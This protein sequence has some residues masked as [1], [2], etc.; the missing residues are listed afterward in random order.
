MGTSG[1][2]KSTLL[3]IMAA[4][5]VPKKA[6]ITLISHSD[7]ELSLKLSGLSGSDV[8]RSHVGVV[9]QESHIFSESV[10]FN[11]SFEQELTGEFQSFW[12][13]VLKKISYLGQWGITPESTLDPKSISLGQRQLIAAI[14]ACYLKKSIILF[15]EISSGLDSDLEEAL[16]EVILL[17]QRESMTFV[18]AHRMETVL[19]ADSILLLEDGRLISSGNH[20][21][22]MENSDSYRNFVFELS[23]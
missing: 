3:N 4:R 18:V 21:N 16:R 17:V 19:T 11:I 12:K 22:L 23:Q 20:E 15:D 1:A 14:R 5:I 6:E 7:E 10:V 8:Y 13:W 9:S 2:G